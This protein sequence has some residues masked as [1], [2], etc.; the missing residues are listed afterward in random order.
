MLIY[1]LLLVCTSEGKPDVYTYVHLHT[2]VVLRPRVT[3]TSKLI[4]LHVFP[5]TRFVA[6][7]GWNTRI[8]AGTE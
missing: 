1:T 8:L 5:E 6:L 7:N 4:V 3:S 2:Q